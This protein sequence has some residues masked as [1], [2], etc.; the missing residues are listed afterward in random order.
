MIQILKTM[1]TM[2]NPELSIVLSNRIDNYEG[3]SIGRYIKA[4]DNNI[5]ILDEADIDWEI[6]SV[7]WN[8]I[9]KYLCDHPRTSHLFENVRHRD[10][11][12]D[13]SVSIAEN[14]R[15]DRFFEYFAKNA[16]IINATKTNILLTNADILFEK[17]ILEEIK[18]MT[19]NSLSKHN[20]Y[21]ARYRTQLNPETL[22]V[23]ET[24]DLHNP[25]WAD[26]H[27]CGAYSGDFLL[28][29]RQMLM[30]ITQGYDESSENHRCGYQTNMDGEILYKLDNN[31]IRM[32]FLKNAY[33]HIWHSKTRQYDG[34]GYNGEGYKNKNDWGYRSYDKKTVGKAEVI[35]K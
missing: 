19:Q 10:L 2:N 28:C 23:L 20:F 9:D 26:A 18:E 29:D 7:E 27:I 13:E 11:I 16:G 17:P 31:G 35:Y 22:S 1:N 15:T 4:Y 24:G 6:L 12:I 3:D 33:C 5:K 21:R 8:P 30:D 14:L 32:Q 25:T 34:G